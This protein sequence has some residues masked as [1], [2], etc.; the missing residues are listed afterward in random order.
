MINSNRVD[1]L[2]ELLAVS[3]IISI[4]TP[5]TQETKGMIDR[6]FISKMKEGS[7][8]INTARGALF[9]DLDLLYD[10]IKINKLHSLC[11]DVLPIEPPQS[12]KLINAWR[13]SEHWLNGRV[14][15]NPH[16]SYY[17]QAAYKEL[18]IN[19]A[20]NALRIFNEEIPYNLL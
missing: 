6:V 18:R 12:C 4:H 13:K 3:D 2:D 11:I 17:S 7:S 15:I 20:K 19:A 16:T 9:Q 14:I 8:I 5:L 10:A 1:Y